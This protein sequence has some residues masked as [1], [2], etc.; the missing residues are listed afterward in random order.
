MISPKSCDYIAPCS[1]SH[2]KLISQNT[3]LFQCYNTDSILFPVSHF[4]P[5]VTES[6]I[7][8]ETLYVFIALGVIFHAIS[9][10]FHAY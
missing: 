3:C 1:K 6:I 10:A 4:L 9:P 8:Q 7:S 5:I 2:L